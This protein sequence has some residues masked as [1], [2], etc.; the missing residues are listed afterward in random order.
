MAYS[1]GESTTLELSGTADLVFSQAVLEHVDDL[2][3]VYAAISAALRPGGFASHAIDFR[4]HHFA[5]AWDGH[6]T[7]SDRTWAIVRGRRRFA[8]NREPLA[9]H[10]QL[11]E[12]AGM[13]VVNVHRTIQ[14]STLAT[15]DLAPRFR[16]LSEK[17]LRNLERNRSGRQALEPFQP[18]SLDRADFAV[19]GPRATVRDVEN[20]LDRTPPRSEPAPRPSVGRA[21]G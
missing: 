1:A 10:L 19:D 15:G 8:I 14:A 6:W 18:A 16:T 21:S 20:C 17:D 2:E 12:A 7:F 13:E 9:T 3:Q 5:R 11:M 4:S